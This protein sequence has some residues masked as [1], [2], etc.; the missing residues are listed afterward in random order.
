MKKPR[1]IQYAGTRRQFRRKGFADA[2]AALLPFVER[3]TDTRG[4]T[5]VD[6]GFT[7]PAVRLARLEAHVPGKWHPTDSMAGPGFS[8]SAIAPGRFQS[9][10]R[11]EDARSAGHD[12]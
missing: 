10:E 6:V 9:T 12:G 1:Y 8:W 2:F 3:A 7:H 11:P 5:N 4:V